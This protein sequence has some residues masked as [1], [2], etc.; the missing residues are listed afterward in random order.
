[1]ATRREFI[2]ALGAGLIARPPTASGQQ[3]PVRMARVGW[4]SYLADPDPGLA[5]LREGMRELGYVEGK[6]Y[7]IVARFASGDFTQLP[8]LVDELAGE[9]VD[10]IVSRGPSVD[11]T[12]SIRSRI[13]VVFA[14]SGDPIEAGFAD[15][16][17]NP[18][19][20][21]TGITFMAMELS[22]KRVEVLKEMIPKASR[23]ALLSNP[24]HAG[25]L[26]EYRVT[27]E[28]A[29][30]L[31]A[32]ITRYLTRNPQEL[33]TAFASIRADNPDAMIVF[34]DSLTL[35]RRK[36]I[37]AFAAQARIPCIYGWTEFAE[38]GGLLSYGP[39][40]TENF[41]T[42]ALFV[43]KV[44]KG[45]DA[46]NIPIEQVKKITLTLNLAAAR[47]LGLSVPQSILVRAD[48]VIE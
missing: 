33:A 24:E 11:F 32:T 5:L 38:S 17:R 10:V 34:P 13:P 16:L 36:D 18:G 44:L 30:R 35:E 19:R 2:I 1:M 9:R 21:M 8:R 20:N 41:K 23:I 39:T 37:T 43:D 22:A 48:K 27:E 15:S 7:V 42:L 29:S 40:L 46:S 28:A 3:Q 26:S 4:L 12:K 25:E 6:S 31:G 14:Y 47:A 45:A